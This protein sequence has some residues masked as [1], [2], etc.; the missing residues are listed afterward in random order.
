LS[1]GDE[2]FFRGKKEKGR[3]KKNSVSGLS[4]IFVAL[5]ST[6]AV[7]VFHPYATASSTWQGYVKPSFPDYAPSGMPDF[8]EKQDFW[9]PTGAF[10]WCGP[11]AVADSLWWLDSEYESLL[12]PNPVAPPTISDH[13][14]LV[15]AFGNWDDHDPRNV[16]P[17]VPLLAS[18]M[19]TDGIVSHDGH[20]GTR[21]TDL[22]RGIQTYLTAQGVSRFFEVHSTEFP[23]FTWIDNE[24]EKCQDV[25][26][27]LEF[28]QFTG[29]VWT[30]S[31]LYTESLR[32]GHFVTCAGVNAT[33][34]PGEVL[35]SDPLQ[36]AFETGADPIGRQPVVPPLHNPTVHNDTQYVSQDGYLV[37]Q[38]TPPPPGPYGAQP[39]WE[40]VNYLQTLDPIHYGP[41]WHTFIRAA[42]AT[43]PVPMSEWPGY[44]KPS[45]PD[46]A[47]SGMPD[48]DEKQDLWG[49]GQGTY[50]WCVP[51]A[52]A[53]SLWWL[54]SKYESILN[55]APDPPPTISDHFNLVTSYS[56]GLWDDHNS[57][58]VDPFVRNLAFLMDTDGQQS[59]D[60]HTGTRWTDIQR[61]IQQY[62]IQQGVA[63]M[64]EV[65]NS[66][67][68]TFE[69][70][71]NETEL[72]QDVEVILE[73]W[74]LTPQGWQTITNPSLEFGH[75]VTSAGVNST[76]SQLLISDPW[77]DAYEA[78][79]APGRSPAMHGYPHG[80]AM[81]NDAQYVSQDAYSVGSFTLPLMPPPPPGYP[82]TVWELQGYLQTMGFDQSYHAFIRG[83]VATSP[84]GIHDVAVTNVTSPKKIICQ[85]MT[86]NVTT[87]VANLG[88]LPESVN[89]TVYAN[90]TSV[91]NG[92]EWNEVVPNATKIGTFT[93]VPIG[94]GNNANLTLVWNTTGF[95]KGNY[96][97]S[98]N[99][100]IV[101]GETNTADNNMTGG[102]IAILMLGDVTLDGFSDGRDIS[103]VSR[104]FGTIPGDP[105]W[106]ADCDVNNDGSA[107]GRD[108]SI[109][110][111]HFGEGGP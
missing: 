24:T 69:W 34:N 64:F 109:V 57:S 84:V 81:H 87:T 79:L 103:K 45:Y 32:G 4:L 56:Q 95:A 28:Y 102:W 22:V 31:S 89:V 110:A 41:T 35:I 62:L 105:R 88:T 76:A 14:P 65:H 43:S 83:A 9:N 5:L 101:P 86:G 16:A 66:S 106:N 19:D 85:T 54:D 8:D 20:I 13:F 111:R 47:P 91:W 78:G 17:L 3:M 10:T 7:I 48:F 80:S 98:A 26:L 71:E 52:V 25:E 90:L 50:T 18:M 23:T 29:V 67:F 6:S 49:P 72:C 15:A 73:F 60:G 99:A 96:T 104:C 58:N 38:W 53:N 97:I 82:S 37:T 108:I 40:L 11:V 75:C 36:D 33:L 42:V 100:T 94:I 55:P 74:Q 92:T 12:N 68:P 77:Q 107:D 30:N 21:F 63:G 70:I 59:H 2:T 61:G 1:L 46:Y 93:N 39:V 44:I 27:F 51:V